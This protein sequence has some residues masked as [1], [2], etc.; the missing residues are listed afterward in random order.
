MRT[1]RDLSALGKLADLVPTAAPLTVGD[2]GS[3]AGK[4][5]T[6]LGRVQLDHGRGPWDEWYL[7]FSDQTWGWLARA[8]GRWYLT[9]EKDASGLP[10]WDALEPAARG[11]FPGTGSI[12]WVVSERGGS[13]LISAEGELPFPAVPLSSGRYADLEGEGYAFASVDYG[14]GS[15][16]PKLFAGRQLKDSEVALKRTALGPRPT[17]RVQ[18]KKLACPGC[19]A[20]VSL[21]VPESCERVGCAACGAVLDHTQG[22][23][24]LLR[25]LN[26]PRVRPFIPLGSTGKFLGRTRIVIGFI[27]RAVEVE[28]ERFTWREYLLF[29]ERDTAGESKAGK[30]TVGQED[31]PEQAYTWLVEDNRHFIH[32][33]PVSTA[34]VKDNYQEATHKGRRYKRFAHGA[35][36]VDFVVG[37]FYWKVMVGDTSQ[38][39]DYVAPP[40]ILSLERSQ[41]EVSWSEGEYVD[42]KA[43]FRAFGL[44]DAPLVPIGV[45]PCQP[46]PHTL[47]LPAITFAL[48]AFL[49]S[50]VAIVYELG[51]H[52]RVLADTQ[53][54]MPPSDTAIAEGRGARPPVTFLPSFDVSDGPTT[55]K[56]ELETN[57]DNG[58]ASLST[59]LLNETTGQVQ[60]LDL[61]A[62]RYAGRTDGES[63]SE[64]DTDAD[65]YYGELHAGRY[66]LRLSPAWDAWPQNAVAPAPSVRV[67]VIEGER[68]PLCCCGAFLLIALPFGLTL[69]RRAS[70]EHKRRENANP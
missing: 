43:L 1:D 65:G 39:V 3:I 19:G 29:S 50:L 66:A 22:A 64:G 53:L 68:S 40:R 51:R 44:R 17:E 25:Q 27:Q 10:P 15:A 67:R 4:G 32:V 61:L 6:V 42:P 69:V 41:N 57:I 63:W 60:E 11:V 21:F 16:K 33:T 34:S 45:S 55:L 20:P 23:L 9:Y 28:G 12:E 31:V 13:A 35:P 18:V 37:E 46:N 2:S 36:V 8:Q 56:V 49:F 7:S 58:W 54:S 48:L 26:A 5:F 70:F 62:E 47:T 24:S 52:T 14:D 38:T 30:S 59:S